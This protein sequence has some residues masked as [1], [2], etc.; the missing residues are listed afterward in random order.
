MIEIEKFNGQ[1]FE[2]WKLKMEDV[3]NFVIDGKGEG[4]GGTPEIETR[5]REQ[6]RSREV[7]KEK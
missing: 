5:K 7:A 6:H 4:K 1:I 2:L 3:G